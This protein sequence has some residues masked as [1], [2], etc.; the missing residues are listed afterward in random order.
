[1]HTKTHTYICDVCGSEDV[2]LDAYAEWDTEIQDWVLRST[3]DQAYCEQC[4]GE[5]T[6]EEK[7]I[8]IKE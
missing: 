4:E 3:F 7:P 2:M 5:C 1:M 8:F 6:L